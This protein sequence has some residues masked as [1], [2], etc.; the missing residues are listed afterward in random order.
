MEA[1][2]LQPGHVVVDNVDIYQ[3]KSVRDTGTSM[4]VWHTHPDTPSYQ[5]C[6]YLDYEDTVELQ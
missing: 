2:H 4:E 1:R 6:T 3:I 5:A